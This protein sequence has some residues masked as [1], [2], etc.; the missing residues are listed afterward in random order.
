MKTIRIY[1]KVEN[2]LLHNVQKVLLNF[3]SITSTQTITQKWTKL[4]VHT[5]TKRLDKAS[6]N[7][8]KADLFRTIIIIFEDGSFK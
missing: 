6:H 2:F 3:H 4:L 5:V 1:F 7:K 8:I